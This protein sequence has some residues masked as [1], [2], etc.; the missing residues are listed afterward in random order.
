MK[1]EVS[2]WGGG[3]PELDFGYAKFGYDVSYVSHEI[4]MTHQMEIMRR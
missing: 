2:G 4:H 3:S 1:K